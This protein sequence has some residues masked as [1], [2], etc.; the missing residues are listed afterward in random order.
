[1]WG[2]GLLAIEPRSGRHDRSAAALDVPEA[3]VSARP[4]AEAE[5]VVAAAELPFRCD[6]VSLLAFGSADTVFRLRTPEPG[7]VCKVQRMSLGLAPRELVRIAARL[8]EGLARSLEQYEV[9]RAVFPEVRVL[10]VHSP[11]FGVPAVAA[12]QAFVPGPR[13]DFFREVSVAELLR[14]TDERPALRAQIARFLRCSITA[15][16]RGGWIVDLGPDN[17][18]LAG[19]GDDAKLVYLNV[20][21]KQVGALR[22]TIR[23]GMYQVFVDRMVD[24]L[25]AIDCD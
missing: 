16:D 21:M 19:E 8:R 5:F 24:L 23:E 3:D 11:L 22:G 10:V 4:K 2:S 25:E 14:I 17:L 9:V 1:M 7:F 15:W 18:V 6:Q 12:L 20:E 13:R